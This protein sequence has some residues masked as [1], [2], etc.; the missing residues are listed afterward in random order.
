MN[1]K[2]CILG[3]ITLF[4][5]PLAF[6]GAETSGTVRI[7]N[8]GET[9]V[10]E[11]SI[12]ADTAS[13]LRNDNTTQLDFFGLGGLKNDGTGAFNVKLTNNGSITIRCKD[14]VDAYS[15]IIPENYVYYGYGLYA[16]YGSTAVNNGTITFSFDNLDQ[17]SVTSYYGK[18]IEAK[19]SKAKG[20]STMINN[21][22][23]LMTGTGSWGTQLRGM[24]TNGGYVTIKNTG[25]VYVDVDRS[26]IVRGLASTQRSTIQNSGIIY[27]RSS[28]SVTGIDA[29]LMENGIS[30]NSGIITAISAGEFTKRYLHLKTDLD[31]RIAGACALNG[32]SLESNGY[33]GGFLENTGILRAVV[34]GNSVSPY[35]IAGG[36]V[37]DQKTGTTV[38]KNTGIISVSSDVKAC[39]ENDFL[40]RKSE[41]IMNE[42]QL[43]TAHKSGGFPTIGA[44]FTDFATTLRD[45][46]STKDFIQAYKANIDM[47]EAKF[48]FRPSDD[49]KAGTAYTVSADTLVTKIRPGLINTEESADGK[50]MTF[51]S[52]T[53]QNIDDY[54]VNVSGMDTL[55]FTSAL[56]D[57]VSVRSVASGTGNTKSYSVSLALNN[58]SGKAKELVNGAAM[59]PVDFV[60]L[61]MDMLDREFDGTDRIARKV[62][63]APF[64]A[65]LSRNDGTD[66]KVFGGL[67]GFDWGFG[68]RLSAGVHG[69]YAL[70]K[71]DDNSFCDKNDLSGF[72]AGLHALYSPVESWWIRAQGS[73]YR[74][75]G[76]VNY[77]MKESTGN[78]LST[79][80]SND[81]NVLYASIFGGKIFELSS[82]NEIRPEL[83]FS[84]MHFLSAHDFEWSYMGY[85]IK[86]YDMEMNAY[87]ALNGTAKVTY[88]HDFAEEKDGGSI[89]ASAGVRA[90]LYAPE[91]KLTM[92]DDDFDDGTTEDLVQGLLDLSY[93]HQIG[94]FFMDAGYRGVFG[95][96]SRNHQFHLSGKWTF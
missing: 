85:H 38:L 49:Y 1:K 30:S 45:F 66:S 78:L 15:G 82:Q 48:I 21:G 94:Q 34:Q 79:K 36:I 68:E 10:N 2:N 63:V 41:I 72:G 61:N 76:D 62:Y 88:I 53:L 59:L 18:G 11:N 74:T 29:R 80:S 16:A 7:Y 50:T 91:V 24:S 26:C 64:T 96:D 32:I 17:E 67:F 89:L 39:A 14:F 65:L 31:P 19:S 42:Y 55:K 4:S 5:I 12:I 35:A 84:Y 9:Y 33:K 43:N 90:R 8:D 44:K 27:L 13:A 20:T 37:L 87:R 60:R 47:S 57:F 54:E 22:T 23:I 70:A 86:G 28:G 52:F 95:A 6:I 69:S 75:A 51:S 83:G 92:M 56:P 40:P 71:P 73:F 93:R 77:S 81:A 46:A 3:A 25:T 58:D